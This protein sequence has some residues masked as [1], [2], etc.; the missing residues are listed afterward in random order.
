MLRVLTTSLLC[1][2]AHAA[3][4]RHPKQTAMVKEDSSVASHV[5]AKAV[6]NGIESLMG[7]S[8]PGASKVDLG[9]VIKSGVAAVDLDEVMRQTQPNENIMHMLT[10]SKSQQAPKLNPKDVKEAVTT[11]NNMIFKA[12]IRLDKKSL[13][14]R[15]FK[16]KNRQTM[17]QV[18]TDLNRL[19]SSL[20]NLERTKITTTSKKESASLASS[21]L[22]EE[23]S[24]QKTAY[25]TERGADTVT[26]AERTSDLRVAEFILKLSKCPT[27]LMQQ[28]HAVSTYGL[29]VCNGT[30]GTT[31]YR[32]N[33]QRIE[34]SANGLSMQGKELLDFALHRMQLPVS[35]TDKDATMH[36]AGLAMG[37]SMQERDDGDDEPEALLQQVPTTTRGPQ[38]TA[39]PAVTIPPATQPRSPEKQAS[40]CRNAKPDCGL[41]YDTFALLWGGMKDLVDE[42]TQK[43]AADDAAWKSLNSGFNA[44]L[45]SLSTEM[46][47]LSALFAEATSDAISDTESQTAKQKQQ[48]QLAAIYKE[49]MSE[50]KETLRQILYTDICGTIKVRNQLISS[51][52]GVTESDVVDC[53]VTEWIDG[54]CSVPCNAGAT[55]GIRQLTREVVVGASLYGAACP[56]LNASMRCNQI[57]CPVDCVL[58]EFS[59]YSRCS[60]ECGGGVQTRTRSKLTLP[61]NGGQSCQT[62]QETQPCNTGSCDRDCS[63]TPW[64][65][66]SACSQACDGGK[67]TKTKSVVIKTRASGT[68]PAVKSPLRFIRSVC[69]DHPCMGDEVCTSTSDIVLA[70][71]SS[72]SLTQKGF[73]ILTTFA[74]KLVGKFHS[75]A[76]IAIVQFGNGHL[77][78]QKVVSDAILAL[79]LTASMKKVSETITSL[80]Y[81]KGFTNMAQAFKKANEVLKRSSRSSAET[82]LIMIT[83]GKP[84][85][86]LQ[87]SQALK[88]LKKAARVVMVHIKQFPP[89]ED[90]KLMKQFASSPDSENYIFINGKKALKLDYAKYVQKTLVQTC[91]MAISVSM[92]ATVNE[93]G[94]AAPAPAPAP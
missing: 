20:A 40:R 94:L 36:A 70:I 3:N 81:Q 16:E 87:T 25:E 26:L 51:T 69:N 74:S 78:D 86:K 58:S 80:K 55:G 5:F 9:D 47:D 85:F 64:S 18:V 17:S 45:E 63:L 43:I 28:G 27:S 60:K 90:V 76:Q 24:T 10:E 22:L 19:G 11:L 35:S 72:G 32:F 34:N 13:E 56:A 12:Q 91:P 15:T 89:K 42:T 1:I 83:D 62:L 65:V 29:Q 23:Q 50:C 39:F 73:D 46:G 79:P 61:L 48:K 38:P 66:F 41:L 31:E 57:E 54:A 77:N 75:N 33:D 4:L 14:C 21:K 44:Q 88:E 7:E 2:N 30:N 93:P 59:E 82:E 6:D 68:C 71:D 49:T 92:N 67:M 52:L 53:A 8:D 37:S 84:S